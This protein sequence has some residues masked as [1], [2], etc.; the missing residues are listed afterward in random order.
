VTV[1][2]NSDPTVLVLG[3]RSDRMKTIEGL[4]DTDGP[5]AIP[6]NRVSKFVDRWTLADIAVPI[7][8]GNR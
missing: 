4:L 6:A 3:L 8:P 7:F 5:L 1:G 2:K